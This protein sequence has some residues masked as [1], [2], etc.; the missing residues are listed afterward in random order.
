MRYLE[1]L[2]DGVDDLPVTDVTVGL[3]DT[4]VVSRFGGLASTLRPDYPGPHGGIRNGGRLAEMGLRSL[5]GYSMSDN[6]LEA[7]VGT[8]AINSFF[9]D[10]SADFADLNGIELIG[11]ISGGRRLAFIGHFP[12]AEKFRVIASKLM[13]FEKVPREDDLEEADIPLRLPD[14]DVVVVTSTVLINHTF[15]EVLSSTRPDAY[16]ILLGPSTPLSPVL[17]DFGVDALCGTVVDDV[18]TVSRYVREAVPFRDIRG[19]RHV[20]LFREPLP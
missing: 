7:S 3:F 14:A 17:F 6:Y 16:V 18:A 13:I 15:D 11:R 10:P 9:N 1:A 2:I 20:T 19:I 4:L 5:A 12:F 8:A